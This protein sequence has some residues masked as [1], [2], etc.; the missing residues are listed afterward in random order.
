MTMLPIASNSGN[1][2]DNEI[3]DGKTDSDNSN[4][5]HNQGGPSGLDCQTV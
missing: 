4:N 5:N 2:N 3:D 1:I